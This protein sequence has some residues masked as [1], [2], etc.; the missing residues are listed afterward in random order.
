MLLPGHAYGGDK[1]TLDEVRRTNPSLQVENLNGLDDV[2]LLD[3]GA[4]IGHGQVRLSEAITIR[5][6]RE[7]VQ[8]LEQR[9]HAVPEAHVVS[10]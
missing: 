9:E 2:S 8:V 3:A 7:R 4:L 1:A 6:Q 10:D 5:D